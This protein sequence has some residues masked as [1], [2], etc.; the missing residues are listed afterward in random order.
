MQVINRSPWVRYPLAVASVLLAT[1]LRRLLNPALGDNAPYVTYYLAVL[2]I[3]W[4][5]GLGPSIVALL[6]G[7]VLAV[8]FVLPPLHSIALSDPAHIIGLGL[9]LCV[10][11][12]GSVLRHETHTARRPAE[13][14]RRTARAAQGA[15]G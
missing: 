9:Y 13:A 6:L 3:A 2:L 5:C 12:I 7:A 10:G 8:Y 1:V 15:L 14:Q 4:A 11:V